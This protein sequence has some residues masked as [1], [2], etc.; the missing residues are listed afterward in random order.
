MKVLKGILSESKD[1][2]LKTKIKIEKKLATLPNGSIKE[3]NISGNKYYYLQER[4][5]NKVVHKYI[6]R[7]KP[8]DLV[9][10]IGQRKLFKS[11]LKKVHEALAIIKKSEGRN[12]D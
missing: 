9:K 5:G 6:G 10:Q 7:K 4:K 8:D 1:Y 11:E 3:R 2:Y 12:H